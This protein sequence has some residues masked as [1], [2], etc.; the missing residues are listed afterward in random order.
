MALAGA[1]LAGAPDAVAAGAPCVPAPVDGSALLAGAVTVSPAPGSRDATP[2]TQISFVGAPAPELSVQSVVGSVSGRHAGRLE[3]YSQGDGASFVPAKPFVAGERVTV[4]AALRAS[5]SVR[6]LRDSFSVAYGDPID[7]TP[8]AI[9]PGRASEEQ[10]FHSRPDLRP[11]LVTVS[12][13]SPAAAPGDVFTAPY[14]GP[15]QAGPMILDAQGA[16]LWFKPLPSNVS[17]SNFRAQEYEGQ[18]VLTWWEGDISVHGYGLGKDEIV[19]ASYRTLA[20]VRAGNGL[21]A[22]LHEFQLTPSGTALI[23]AYEPLLCDLAGVGGPSSGAVTD[24]VVQEVDVRTGLVRMQWTSLDHVALSESY[25]HPWGSLSWPYDF[26]HVNSIGLDG[27]GGLLVSARNTWTVYDVSAST[28][29]V[30]WQLG[31]RHSSFREGTAVRTAWQH[32][33]R[34]LPDGS[35]SIFD[36]GSSPTVH[37]QSRGIVVRV[38]AGSATATLVTQLTHGPPLIAESQG[39]LQL[40][41]NGDWFVG[42]GQVPDFSEYGP[43]GELL[44][45]AHLPVHEQ[46]YR[47]FRFPWT[48]TPPHRP[49]LAFQATGGGGG[50]LYASWNGATLVSAWRVLAGKAPGALQTVGQAQQTGFET[51]IAVAPGT[52]GPYLA[53]EALDSSE[54]APVRGG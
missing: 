15:G 52:A 9:H 46:S 27:A 53:V 33:P 11:P 38:E 3:P 50:T 40:L 26:F 34:L 23:T 29:Q 35:I 16:L 54:R 13:S 45:D 49:A 18:P 2:A 43:A 14:S 30:R 7:S 4:R 28:G 39:N 41:A 12:A 25:E 51:A 42:W 5:G 32:D 24:G 37:G 21:E 10:S 6:P 48:G 44:F 17:A 19:D 8:E 31:G 47:S 1:M 22:D 20:Q 36:N